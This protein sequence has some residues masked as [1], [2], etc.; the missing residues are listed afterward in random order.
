MRK[1]WI[2]LWLLLVLMGG[3]AAPPSAPPAAELSRAETAPPLMPLDL[4]PGAKLRVVATTSL[5][6]DVVARI[7]GEA[8]DLIGLLLPGADPHGYQA[9]PDDFRKSPFRSAGEK[10]TSGGQSRADGPAPAG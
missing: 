10:L 4:P 5:V 3:C 2:G 6:A 7:G 1:V 8:I 9:T